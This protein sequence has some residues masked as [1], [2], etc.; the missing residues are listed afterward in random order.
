MAS[1]STKNINL[2][3]IRAALDNNEFFLEYLPTISLKN[4]RCVGAETLIRWRRSY[5]VVPPLDFI[6]LV[7]NTILSGPITYWV[8]ETAAHELGDWL[9][10]NDN[11]HLS[12]NIPPEIL[13]RGGLEYVANKSN[14]KEV[15]SHKFIVEVTERGIPDQLGIDQLNNLRSLGVRVA[16][17]DVWISNLNSVILCRTGVD[18][19]KLD[20]AFSD[21]MLLE[22]WSSKKIERLSSLLS[23]SEVEIIAEGVESMVQVNILREAGIQMAQGWYFSPSLSADEFKAFF[24]MHQ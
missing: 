11:I 23:T 6:P 14:L 5:G 13:G 10:I 18:I 24:C 22:S 1:L 9:R 17:D 15:A 12:F 16:L 19:I 2:D 4:N 21:E 20:K 7:E 3:S 8:I